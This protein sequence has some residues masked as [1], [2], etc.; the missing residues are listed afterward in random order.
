MEHSFERCI[1]H[2]KHFWWTVH[3]RYYDYTSCVTFRG[4]IL[5][6]HMKMNSFTFELNE[7]PTVEIQRSINP[8]VNCEEL[9]ELNVNFVVTEYY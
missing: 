4:E 6:K 1:S 7:T 9:F 8:D 2:L 5:H 3:V